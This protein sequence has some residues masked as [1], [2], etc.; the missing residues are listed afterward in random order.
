VARTAQADARVLDATLRLFW[1]IIQM[2]PTS[3]LQA[4]REWPMDDQLE[5][6]FR[7]WDQ[8]VENSFRP[9][10]TEDLITELHRRLA[11]HE[12]DPANVL[13]W[14]QVVEKVK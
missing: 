4:V 8:I 12:A 14:Q 7:L 10:P 9:E 3:T 6:V 5:L 2:N 11:A 13:S 1:G